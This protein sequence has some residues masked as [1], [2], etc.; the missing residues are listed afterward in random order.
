MFVS[1]QVV[2]DPDSPE[3][4]GGLSLQP[5]FLGSQGKASQRR[6]TNTKSGRLVHYH[7][8]NTGKL[9]RSS[10]CLLQFSLSDRNHPMPIITPVYPQ[11]NTSFNVSPSTQAIISEEI[12]RGMI[13]KGFLLCYVMFRL[14][15]LRRKTSSR[16]L[17]HRLRHRSGHSTEKSK[18]VHTV[19]NSQLS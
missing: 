14:V 2:A 1:C 8:S 19:R 12:D 16:F 4:S 3:R 11:Q 18:L 6:T 7:I 15:L 9:N 17:I 10:L 13:L 5:A